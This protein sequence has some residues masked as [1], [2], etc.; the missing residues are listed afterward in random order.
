[1]QSVDRNAGMGKLTKRFVEGAPARD[2]AYILWDGDIPGF[3][4][5]VMPSG[6]KTFILQYRMAGARAP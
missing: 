2:K 6:R 1:M 4:V 5:R 3:G